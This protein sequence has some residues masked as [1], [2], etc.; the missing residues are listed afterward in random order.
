MKRGLDEKKTPISF[1][2]WGHSPI[3][4]GLPFFAM[5]PSNGSEN[6]D[7]NTGPTLLIRILKKEKEFKWISHSRSVSWESGYEEKKISAQDFR[8]SKMNKESA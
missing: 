7:L 8:G 5:G 4:R 6:R 2:K 1:T 3:P